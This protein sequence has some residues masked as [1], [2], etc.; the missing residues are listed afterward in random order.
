MK[1]KILMGFILIISVVAVAGCE[2]NITGSIS[3][4]EPKETLKKDI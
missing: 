4:D 2:P 3:D 1:K